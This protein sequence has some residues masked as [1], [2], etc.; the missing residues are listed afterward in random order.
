MGDDCHLRK[1][2]KNPLQ[3][4]KRPSR[5]DVQSLEEKLRIEKKKTYPKCFQ[6]VN[7]RVPF[8]R[9]SFYF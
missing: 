5:K 2:D 7:N 6:Y 1:L 3:L 8:I 9:Y 4:D